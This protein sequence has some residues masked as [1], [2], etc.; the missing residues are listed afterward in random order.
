MISRHLRSHPKIAN[1]ASNRKHPGAKPLNEKIAVDAKNRAAGRGDRKSE[2]SRDPPI[3]IAPQNTQDDIE[4][5]SVTDMRTLC[6]QATDEPIYSVSLSL[7]A[8]LK[9]TTRATSL[10]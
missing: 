7:S 9:V 10:R 1:E 5:Y 4:M 8:R 6:G 3:P 2:K